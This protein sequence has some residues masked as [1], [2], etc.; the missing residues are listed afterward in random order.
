MSCARNAAAP[1]TDTWR[2]AITQL[3]ADAAGVLLLHIVHPH[4]APGLLAR[5]ILGDAEAASLVRV[6]VDT[7]KRIETAATTAPMECGCCGRP[8]H[9]GAVVC[10]AVAERPDSRSGLAFALCRKCTRDAAA[11]TAKAVKA[12]QNLWPNGR[13][14]ELTHRKGGTA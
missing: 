7:I 6:V 5:A 13:L 8:L 2:D 12:L 3:H 10:I 1:G 9:G 11:V 4:D 14:I